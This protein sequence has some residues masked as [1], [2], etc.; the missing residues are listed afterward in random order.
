MAHARGD[1]VCSVCLQAELHQQFS[2]RYTKKRLLEAASHHDQRCERLLRRCR[3]RWQLEE[4]YLHDL[5]VLYGL[6][7]AI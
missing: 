7:L 1:G 4:R 5:A 6:Q 2:K 3:Q